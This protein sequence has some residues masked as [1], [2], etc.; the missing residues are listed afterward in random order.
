MDAS[1]L[2]QY[3]AQV[4]TKLESVWRKLLSNTHLSSGG[5]VRL[6]FRISS[7]GNLISPR[8]SRPSGNP[9]LDKL[10]LEVC[11]RIGHLGSPPGGKFSSVLEIPFRVN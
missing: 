1:E 3:L 4:K 5:E 6:S 8:I 11:R 7:N 9:E 10:V 2:N